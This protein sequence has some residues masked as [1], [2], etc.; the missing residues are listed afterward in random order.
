M[1]RIDIDIEKYIEQFERR[2]MSLSA[3]ARKENVSE[4]TINKRINEYYEKKGKERPKFKWKKILKIDI[5]KYIERYEK[6]EITVY[7]IAQDEKVS[8]DTITRR[9]EEYYEQKGIE[10]EEKEEKEEKEE[11]N[12][13]QYISEYEKGKITIKEIA[14]KESVCI[15]IAKEKLKQYYNGRGKKPPRAGMSINL[16]K[17]FLEKGMSKEEIRKEA[18]KRNIV[19][20]DEYFKKA[21]EKISKEE[22]ER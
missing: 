4:V 1:E 19:I 8:R 14:D 16:L 20:P 13:Q 3:I 18:F 9:I 5:E 17:Y 22:E 15:N 7:K 12:I 6:K 11:I 21:E 2:E 10:R